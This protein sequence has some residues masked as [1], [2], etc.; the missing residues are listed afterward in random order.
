[1]NI[2]KIF[3]S[4]NLNINEQGIIKLILRYTSNKTADIFIN[5]NIKIMHNK[6]GYK[7]NKIPYYNTTTIK[8]SEKMKTIYSRKTN[9][10]INTYGLKIEKYEKKKK[11]EYGYYISYIYNKITL[12]VNIYKR[13]NLPKE[14]YWD[15]NENISKARVKTI[16]ELKKNRFYKDYGRFYKNYSKF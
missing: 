9:V 12:C 10:L 8:L 2:I 4:N 5:S 3:I 13:E 11:K 7:N 6:Y 15:N 16:I 1:M 14:L